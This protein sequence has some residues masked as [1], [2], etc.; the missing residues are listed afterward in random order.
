MEN[1]IG[2]LWKKENE[3]GEFFTGELIKDDGEKIKIV[4]FK[5]NYKNKDTQ[6]DYRILKAKEQTS[7][8]EIVSDDM[9]PF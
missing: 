3:K 5:N 1:S 2:A 9:L 7:K 4:V 6:P 8:E